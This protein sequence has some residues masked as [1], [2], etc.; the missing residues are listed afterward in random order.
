LLAV[1]LLRHGRRDVT[2][3]RLPGADHG[4]RSSAGTDIVSVIRQTLQWA[5]LKAQSPGGG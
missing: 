1:E 4:F 2:L 5:G 3:I